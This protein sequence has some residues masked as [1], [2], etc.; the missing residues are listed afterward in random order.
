LRLN[1][2]PRGGMIG[3]ERELTACAVDVSAYHRDRPGTSVLARKA[4]LGLPTGAALTIAD[5]SGAGLAPVV[6]RMALPVNAW[7]FRSW[8]FA[9]S[10]IGTAHSPRC[11]RGVAPSKRRKRRWP[12]GKPRTRT[13]RHIGVKPRRSTFS[14]RP[15]EIATDGNGARQGSE[16]RHTCHSHG[17]WPCPI[18]SHETNS[19]GEND[20]RLHEK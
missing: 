15:R 12:L 13:I 1:R 11:Q 9:K 5:F 3:Q 14:G 18:L 17:S 19:N 20:A 7:R 8:I 16:S 10:H 6:E 2:D 4:Q